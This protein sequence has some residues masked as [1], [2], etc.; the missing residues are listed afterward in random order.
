MFLSM[1]VRDLNGREF[2]CVVW[3]VPGAYSVR[4]AGVRACECEAGGRW[5]KGN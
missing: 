5:D 4:L 2:E 3:G 1:G